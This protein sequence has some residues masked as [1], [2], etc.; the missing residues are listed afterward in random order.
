M[1]E[2]DRTYELFTH[3]RKLF[4]CNLFC[5]A[6]LQLLIN[7][8]CIKTFYL[9][10]QEFKL[11]VMCDVIYFIFNNS[12][13]PTRVPVFGLVALPNLMLTISPVVIFP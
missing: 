3:H 7:S 13:D 6:F 5:N 4:S 8:N 12:F 2:F 9:C 11:F 1:T 10:H